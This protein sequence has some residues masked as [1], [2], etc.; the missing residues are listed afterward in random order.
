MAFILKTDGTTKELKEVNLESLQ[1]AV[2]GY[3]QILSTNK[4]Q[5]IVVDEEGKLKNKPV[6]KLATE[7]YQDSKFRNIADDF[8]DNLDDTD[9]DMD[10]I[11]NIISS[12]GDKIVG[13]VVILEKGELQDWQ[14]YKKWYTHNNMK[15]NLIYTNYKDSIW[16]V[17]QKKDNLT[18]WQKQVVEDFIARYSDKSVEQVDDIIWKLASFLHDT[19]TNT[20]TINSLPNELY[21]LW[22]QY[23]NTKYNQPAISYN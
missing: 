9:F 19:T 21:E 6:N 10:N 4:G 2:G 23:L 3:I 22:T 7:L 1:K 18:K 13:D 5:E 14:Q 11:I 17:L 16:P 8:I 12:M 15:H 20:V